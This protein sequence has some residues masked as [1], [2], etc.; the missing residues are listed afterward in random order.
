MKNIV[1][2][3]F[4]CFFAYALSGDEVQRFE[5]AAFVDSFDFANI[6]VG[7]SGILF[8][9]ETPEGTRKVLEHVLE[10][11]ANLIL[12]RNCSGGVMRYQSRETGYPPTEAPLD[13]RRL[14]NN[15]PVHGWVGYHL[16]EPD[17]LYY[18]SAYCRQRELGF[19]VHWPFEE[20]HGQSW[21]VGPWNLEHPQFWVSTDKGLIWPGRC[22]LAYPEVMAHKMLL[23]D[24]LL[25]RGM[26]HLFIDV[27][28]SGGWGPRYEYIGPVIEEW[29]RRYGKEPP[30]DPRD[31]LWCRFVSEQTHAF[32][33]NVKTHLQKSERKVRLMVGI[34]VADIVNE[35]PDLTLLSCGVDW[36]R[37]VRENIIDTLVVMSVKWDE[38]KNLTPF[39]STRT[40]YQS[41][42]DACRG[43]C[44][45]L[46]PISAYNFTNRGLKGY[47][48]ATGLPQEKIAEELMRIAWETGADGVCFECVD[49]NNYIEPVRATLRELLETKYCYKREAK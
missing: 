12:W 13:K 11:G 14:P 41:V 5:A 38:S 18:V 43:Y 8:D 6:K 26:D 39:E 35:E 22:S 34:P 45:V 27:W 48:V 40:I 32:F 7:N 36:K 33:I 17:I 15:R 37:L 19:G 4:I 20:A 46:F 28:R 42:M 30:Q 16:C 2:A 44:E 23:L 21:T 10:T 25:E 29:R 31:P 47:Q 3:V 49:F 9:T 24:E 1:V